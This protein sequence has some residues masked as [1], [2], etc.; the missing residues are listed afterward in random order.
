MHHIAEQTSALQDRYPPS[1]VHGRDNLVRIPTW[2][3]HLINGWYS[4]PHRQFGG[5]SPREYLRGK[6]WEERMRIGR[7]A[8]IEQGVLLP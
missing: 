1:L 4:K 7:E 5:L 8:L 6:D 3:H 2:K